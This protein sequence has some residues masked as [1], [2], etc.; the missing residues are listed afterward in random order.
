MH[1]KLVTTITFQLNRLKDIIR[2]FR[3]ET[4]VLSLLQT[5]RSSSL[6]DGK[7]VFYWQQRIKLPLGNF[8]T[9]QLPIFQLS[10]KF[11]WRMLH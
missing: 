2:D 5:S 11:G 4:F 3:H 7:M 6:D 9:G 10:E 1:A 8:S